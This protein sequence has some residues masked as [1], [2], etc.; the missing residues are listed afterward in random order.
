M[1]DVSPV[2][3]EGCNMLGVSNFDGC[4]RTSVSN[5]VTIRNNV[6]TAS[7]GVVGRSGIE[8]SRG[9]NIL[10]SNNKISKL[11]T[12][13]NTLESQ[14]RIVGNGI[15][16]ADFHGIIIDSHKTA[17]V[18]GNNIARCGEAGILAVS[19]TPISATNELRI[20]NN[21]LRDCGLTGYEAVILVDSVSN[22]PGT[23]AEFHRWPEHL[24]FEQ[25]EQF[26][27]VGEKNEYNDGCGQPS[28]SDCV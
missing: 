6:M 28:S 4:V 22:F 9:D 27:T 8:T 21:I 12:P 2:L 16:D 15:I 18:S 13:I 11:V 7:P 5:N 14:I 19:T 17:N 20:E 25:L 24:T 26:G 3:I 23:I 1:V 10:V